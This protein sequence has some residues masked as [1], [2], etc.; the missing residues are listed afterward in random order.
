MHAPVDEWRSRQAWILDRQIDIAAI[1]SPTGGEA[2]RAEHMASL[3]RAVPT[4]S[5]SRDRHGNVC[6]VATPHDGAPAPLVCMAHLDT[7][8]EAGTPLVV[9][10]D[11]PI[12]RCPGIGDNSRGLAVLLVLAHVLGDPAIRRRLTR[13]VH[14][15]ATVG[16]EGCGDLLGA[17][18]W[19]DDHAHAPL[20]P[21]AA[22]VIDGPGDDTIVHRAPGSV[23]LRL[24]VSGPGGHSWTDA[25][26]ANPIHAIGSMLAGIAH[27]ASRRPG[28]TSIAATRVGGGESLTAIP[29]V[30]WAD[31]DIRGTA[32]QDIRTHR[33]AV[34]AL[35]AEAV[36]TETSRHPHT[37]LT[38]QVTVLSERPAGSVGD[39]HPLVRAA[40]IATEQVG[41]VA[42]S[43][44]ASTDANVPLS[45]GIPA[46]ALGAGGRGGG[47][48]TPDEWFDDRDSA[49]GVTRL[50]RL[51]LGLATAAPSEFDF[52][53]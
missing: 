53:R 29:R 26:T 45:R 44:I 36:Q 47:A 43:A 35:A 7:V 52:A 22:I 33:A 42:R 25:D 5:V 40:I 15:V 24:T 34:L 30:C 23:R 41:R 3:L 16:E 17:R 46:I 11:G 38:L 37:P 6:A 32:E 18:G 27:L 20:A 10:R 4:L 1:A 31:I 39:R 2:A 21:W 51:V 9:Q 50:L 14:L 48:H 28:S 49:V 19:F 8:F 13:P 12:L